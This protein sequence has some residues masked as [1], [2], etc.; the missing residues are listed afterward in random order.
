MSWAWLRRLV[1]RPSD[2]VS[3][4]CLRHHLRHELSRGWEGPTWQSP[5]TVARMR[6]AEARHLRLLKRG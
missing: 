4:D 1:G 3:S 6:R 2:A 5:K